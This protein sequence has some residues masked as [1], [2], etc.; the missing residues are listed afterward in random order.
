MKF[1]FLE[2]KIYY[3]ESTMMSKNCYIMLFICL[4]KVLECNYMRVALYIRNRI[5][6]C[7]LNF[8]TH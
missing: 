3:L 6:T 2:F 4:K 1:K 5:L 7:L 8:Q